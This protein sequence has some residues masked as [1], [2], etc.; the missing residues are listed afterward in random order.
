MT[1][2]VEDLMVPVSLAADVTVKDVERAAER[3]RGHATR[4]PLLRQDLLGSGLAEGVFLKPENLQRTGSF[5]FRGA[6]NTLA[7]FTPSERRRG[8]VTSSSGNHGQAVAA[9]AQILDMKACV[10]MPE[11]AVQ[12]K[13]DAVR[14]YG[15]RVVFSGTTSP[16]REATAQEIGRREGA[17]VIG[18][19]D[20]AR[21]IAGQGTAGLEIAEDLPDADI[22]L[23]PV[24][25]GGLISGVALAIKAKRPTACVFGVE[26]S[27][28]ADAAE[29]L[30]TGKIVTLGTIDTIA[31]GLRTSRVGNLNFGIMS[32]LLDGIVTVSDDEIREAMRDLAFKSK[33]TVEPSGAVAVAAL[34]TGRIQV[35]GA[36]V[37]V[38]ISGGNVDPSM[39]R[40]ILAGS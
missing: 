26:P 13:V 12:V 27:G 32:R 21:I 20:D 24:G 8:V 17:V 30:R 35:G 7:S 6:Y 11:H 38:L 40:E 10:V 34:L 22:V 3:L 14:S 29:S 16:E 5:K 31:D 23:S 25:G 28:A 19:F 2:E 4:T 37:V 18:S 9:A 36:K 1:V 15:A 39:Y 33:L